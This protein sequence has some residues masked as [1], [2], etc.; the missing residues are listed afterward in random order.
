MK[1]Y[2]KCEVCSFS[3]FIA[4]VDPE[5]GLLQGNIRC[6]SKDCSGS[7]LATKTKI[8]EAK[9]YSARALWDLSVGLGKKEDSWIPEARLKKILE[10]AVIKEIEVVELEGKNRCII[11]NI[12]LSDNTVVHLA[13]STH[14]ATVYKVTR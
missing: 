5:L 11:N 13:S 2:F 6:P 10:G 14:G 12:T 4:V 7:L 3:A 9:F 1:R 8:K